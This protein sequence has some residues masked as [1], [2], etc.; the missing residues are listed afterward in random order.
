MKKIKT[1]LESRTKASAKKP[2]LTMEPPGVKSPGRESW[3]VNVIPQRNTLG[4]KIWSRILGVE[5]ATI[6]ILTMLFA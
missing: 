2:F 3:Q 5:K 4:M 6:F 1:N